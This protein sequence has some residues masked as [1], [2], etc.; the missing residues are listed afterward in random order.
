MNP[1]RLEDVRRQ[2]AEAATWA[3]PDSQEFFRIGDVAAL[4]AIADA[5]TNPSDELI[6]RVTVLALGVPISQSNEATVR[7]VL[8]ALGVATS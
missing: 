5:V 3:E 7:V 6:R 8:R 1:D 4:F 2:L